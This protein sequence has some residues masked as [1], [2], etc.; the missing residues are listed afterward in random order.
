MGIEVAPVMD[1]ASDDT[2]TNLPSASH[3][4]IDPSSDQNV[5]AIWDENA[6]P[7]WSLDNDADPTLA[8]EPAATVESA[9][10]TPAE[11]ESATP[12]A[13]KVVPLKIDSSRVE[14]ILKEVDLQIAYLQFADAEQLLVGPLADSPNEPALL[15]KLA[16]VHVAA[17]A[18][19]KFVELAVRLS[20]NEAFRNSEHWTKI[21]RMGETVAPTHPLFEFVATVEIA[22]DDF[23]HVQSRA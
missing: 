10:L 4:V 8:L 23:G 16:E 13:G 9:T 11:D 5:S 1:L 22:A 14:P 3:I 19:D 6:V 12:T 17:G 18:V 2:A 20:E 7:N 21:A 15:V